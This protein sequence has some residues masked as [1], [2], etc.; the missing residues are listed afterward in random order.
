MFPQLM[1]QFVKVGFCID[2]INLESVEKTWC[3]YG[4]I[5]LDLP[6]K[7]ELVAWCEKPSHPSHFFVEGVLDTRNVPAKSEFLLL[8]GKIDNS[9]KQFHHG[10]PML[11]T[12]HELKFRND[13]DDIL[14]ST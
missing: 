5:Y 10:G 11:K 2:T 9:V 6:S 14:I 12:K 4:L 3:L 1:S 8:L 13:T 7:C